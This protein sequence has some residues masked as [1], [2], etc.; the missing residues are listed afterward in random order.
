LLGGGRS[1]VHEVE[2]EFDPWLRL[3]LWLMSLFVP[4][5]LL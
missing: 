1:E 3:R 5:S 2:P 4:E